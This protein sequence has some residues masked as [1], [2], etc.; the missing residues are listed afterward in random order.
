MLSTDRLQLRMWRESDREPFAAINADPEVMEFFP[1]TLGRHESDALADRIQSGLTE[2][3][4]GL[5]AVEVKSG[6]A[7]E[8]SGEFIGYV[9]LSIPRFEAHFTPCVEIGWR[10]ARSAWGHG[11]ATEA[12]RGAIRFGF[13]NLHLDEIVS[14]TA[15]INDRS[16]RVMRRLGMTHDSAGDFD[17]PSLPQGD[18]L[19]RHVL[20]RLSNPA[21][22]ISHSAPIA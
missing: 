17:H 3:G 2:R 18:R 14:F 21:A 20:F 22:S 1:S 5:W 4:W 6:L 12:A 19:S 13:E 10:L 7:N 15:S 11:F 8:Q 9:G 16:R